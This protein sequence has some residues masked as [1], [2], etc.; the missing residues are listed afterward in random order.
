MRWHIPSPLYFT[1]TRII[2]GPNSVEMNVLKVRQ[3]PPPPLPP[4]LLSTY[5]HQS[6]FAPRCRTSISPPSEQPSS[7]TYSALIPSLDFIPNTQIP[8]LPFYRRKR[9]RSQSRR[10]R[11]AKFKRFTSGVIVCRSN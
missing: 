5:L 10:K 2:S 11:A 4:P 3:G 8:M 1:T 9:K 7:L 6:Q